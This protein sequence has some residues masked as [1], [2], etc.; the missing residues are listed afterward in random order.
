MGQKL[1]GRT[2]PAGKCMFCEKGALSKE[3][4]WPEWAS[5]MLPR[6]TDNRRVEELFTITEKTRLAEL[7][8]VNSRQGHTWTKK[9]RVVCRACNNGWMS[10]LETAAK[11]ILMPLISTKPHI[12]TEEAMRILA[13]WIALKVMV[14]ERNHPEESVTPLEDRAKFRSTREIPPNS[15]IWIA[16]CGTGGWE[17][18]YLR[19][20]ATVST[21]PIVMPHHRFKNI[22][23]VAFGVGDLFVLA[24]QTTVNGVLNSNPTRSD[25][26]IPLFPVVRPCTW[27]PLQSLSVSEANNAADTLDRSF[28]GSNVRWAPGFPS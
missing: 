5:A 17:S 9:L 25:A 24:I 8:E 14:G 10:V 21:S 7:P 27:P 6:Y 19:H 2:R 20:A 13:Q 15:R 23:S 16:K 3:H 26:L 18:G 28:R 22:H 4:F 12:L 11:P 1:H